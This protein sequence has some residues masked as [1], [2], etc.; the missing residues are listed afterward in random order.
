MALKYSTRRGLFSGVDSSRQQS[1]LVFSVVFMEVR[2]M[3]TDG[4]M[5]DGVV[6]YGENGTLALSV[7]HFRSR[8]VKFG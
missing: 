2:E 8:S 7:I 6:K 5:P 1:G 3:T 4:L